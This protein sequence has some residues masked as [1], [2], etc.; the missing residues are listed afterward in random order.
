[1]DK[2]KRMQCNTLENWWRVATCQPSVINIFGTFLGFC[3]WQPP[4]RVWSI[5]G[6]IG[7]PCP[8]ALSPSS[9][10]IIYLFNH[11]PLIALCN[12]FPKVFKICY[13]RNWLKIGSKERKIIEQESMTLGL[14]YRVKLKSK[15]RQKEVARYLSQLL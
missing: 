9:S 1:M 15:A 6:A 3:N 14:F 12:C 8:V 4:A 2:K 11:P 7:S 13:H 5:N 10:M